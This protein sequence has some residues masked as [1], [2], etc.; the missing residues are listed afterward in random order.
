MLGSH[1]E[2]QAVLV[3][4]CNLEDHVPDVHLLRLIDRFV[5]D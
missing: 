5:V 1:Q 2:S 3:F 4:E